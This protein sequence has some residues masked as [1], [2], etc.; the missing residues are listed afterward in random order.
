[1][2]RGRFLLAEGRAWRSFRERRDRET[3][4]EDDLDFLR[5]LAPIGFWGQ[6][7][8]EVE[9]L[10]Q[11]LAA[12]TPRGVLEIGTALGGT[13]FLLSRVAH[14]RA[15]L[16]TVDLPGG[17]FGGGYGREWLP[18]LRSMPRSTQTLKLVRGDSHD[19]HTLAV[20]RDV[21]AQ[22]PVD[23]L[24]I[25]GDHSYDGVKQDFE[26]YSPLVRPGGFV[27]LH[28]IV[29]GP[30]RLVGGVPRFW[31]EIK[32]SYENRELVADR[33]PPHAADLVFTQ[34]GGWGLG[35]VKVS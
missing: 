15:T 18:V 25:D 21:F 19:R 26:W 22:A 7:R 34:E 12:D 17:P 5:G 11:I 8:S 6:K 1:M 29:P 14:P 13:L 31:N 4:L 9:A 16:A 27:A 32:A 2:D 10:L 3:R 23:F 20:V 24:L 33:L 35:L 28:D 30:E